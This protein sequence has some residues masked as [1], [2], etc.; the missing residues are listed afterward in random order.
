MKNVIRGVSFGYLDFTGR[1][2]FTVDNLKGLLKDHK[3]RV[4]YNYE[5]VSIFKKPLLIFGAIFSILVLVVIVKRLNMSAFEHSH[6]KTDWWS[7]KN[8]VNLFY[9]DQILELS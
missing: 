3:L 8:Y 4:T 2:T 7:I 9:Y 1:P 5:Y 6:V